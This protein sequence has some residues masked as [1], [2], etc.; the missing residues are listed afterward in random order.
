MYVGGWLKSR[1]VRFTPGKETLY[2]LYRRL[3]GSQCRS[4]EVGK[5]SSPPARR[6]INGIKGFVF[7]TGT[8]YVFC[9]S[10]FPF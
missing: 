4:V 9:E 5:I 2:P 6:C 1:L 7:V 3:G 8:Q 10:E